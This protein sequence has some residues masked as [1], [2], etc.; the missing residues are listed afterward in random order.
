MGSPVERARD[1]GM[2]MAASDAAQAGPE[3][4]SVAA[5]RYGRAEGR[6]LV[7]GTQALIRLLI[8]QSA[9]DRAEGF[10]TAGYVSGYRGSPLA[11]FDREIE[12]AGKEL[13]GTEIRFQP[14]LNEDLAATA[15]WGT[16]QLGFSKGAR[17]D[18]VFAIWYGKGPGIDRS[19]DAIR[20]A[21]A[22]GTAP[23]GGVLL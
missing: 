5:S 16:Q 9:L 21:N 6:I 22:A 20:H 2:K 13:Q 14:G 15:V 7:S 1:L 3:A 12:K 23:K 18:G 10:N 11:G 19:M 4:N 8:E 17:H